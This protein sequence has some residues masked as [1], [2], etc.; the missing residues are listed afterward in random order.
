[1]PVNEDAAFEA[2]EE[3]KALQIKL[4][5]IICPQTSK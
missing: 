2:W 3:E 5:S 1:M 4:I